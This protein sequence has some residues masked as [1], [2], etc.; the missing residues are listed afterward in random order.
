MDKHGHRGEEGLKKELIGSPKSSESWTKLANDHSEFFRVDTDADHGVSL[1][2]RHVTERNERGER[3]ILSPDFTKKLIET[4][5][6][7]YGIQKEHVERWKVWVPVI[8]VIVASAINILFTLFHQPPV[9]H[10]C[11]IIKN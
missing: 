11:N 1:V 8:V 2:S 6:E 5:I 4:A 9:D 3:D 7:L 10:G